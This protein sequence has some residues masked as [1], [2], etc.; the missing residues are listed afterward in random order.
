MTLAGHLGMTLA[1]LGEMSAAEFDLWAAFHQQYPIGQERADLH[2]GIVASTVANFS[3]RQLRE[4]ESL[5]PAD[6]MP[7]GKR[8][9]TEEVDPVT[10]FQAM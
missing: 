10:F 7:C 1:Q 6:F 8:E 2:A 9:A 4:G 3:G 5:A